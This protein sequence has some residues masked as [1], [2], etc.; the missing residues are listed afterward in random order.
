MGGRAPAGGVVESPERHGVWGPHVVGCLWARSLGRPGIF[1][2][3]K[4]FYEWALVIP[5]ISLF[6]LKAIQRIY[7]TLPVFE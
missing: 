3:M 4:I 1:Y 6:S 5:Q 2:P 7:H